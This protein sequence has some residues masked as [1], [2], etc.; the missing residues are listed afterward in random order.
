MSGGTGA[1]DRISTST[2]LRLVGT[3]TLVI[4]GIATGLFGLTSS[5]I[6]TY[7]YVRGSITH[8]EYSQEGL[9][10]SALL[11]AS[12]LMLLASKYVAPHVR[13]NYKGD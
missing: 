9:K 3:A 6:D 11:G 8:R 7:N 5:G 4:A 1:D 2:L 13:S 12:A 10:D